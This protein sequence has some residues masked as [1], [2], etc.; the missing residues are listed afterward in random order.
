MWDVAFHILDWLLWG[1][2]LADF[3]LVSFFQG[4][5]L[6]YGLRSQAPSRDGRKPGS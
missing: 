1:L 6:W 4:A 5:L 2:T 3:V